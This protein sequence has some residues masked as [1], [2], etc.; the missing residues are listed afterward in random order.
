MKNCVLIYDDEPELLLLTKMMLER[1]KYF[2]QTR[3]CCDNII[4]D[5]KQEKPGIIIMDLRIPNMGGEE[6]VKLIKND[7]S[8][9]QIPVILFSGRDDIEKISATANANGYLKKPFT[10]DELIEVVEKYMWE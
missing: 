2:V 7:E 10:F 8:T 9:R 4:E 6:A 1:K 3:K 5:V